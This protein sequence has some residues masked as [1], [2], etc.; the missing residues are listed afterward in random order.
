MKL[1]ATYYEDTD[2][3]FF[4]LIFLLDG[5]IIKPM[6]MLM[7]RTLRLLISKEKAIP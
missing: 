2:K 1:H 4:L 5:I 3:A 7:S 6:L